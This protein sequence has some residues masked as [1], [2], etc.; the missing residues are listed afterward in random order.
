MV[1]HAMLMLNWHT[2]WISYIFFNR[3]SIVLRFSVLHFQ[4]QNLPSVGF[5]PQE[6]DLI[7]R[8]VYNSRPILV[9]F[10]LFYTFC[11]RK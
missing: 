8:P 2:A 5:D 10:V 6:F 1:N 3:P 9:R 4:G 11:L 7:G